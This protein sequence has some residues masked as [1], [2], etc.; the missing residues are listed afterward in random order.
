MITCAVRGKPI[1][2]L[3]G[4][5]ILHEHCLV[6]ESKKQESSYTCMCMYTR[7]KDMAQL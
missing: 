5:Y 1:G 3:Q 4:H 6:C 2:S 7:D